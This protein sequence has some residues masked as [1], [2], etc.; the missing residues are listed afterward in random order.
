MAWWNAL[1]EESRRTM[2][3]SPNVRD[4]PT[5]ARCWLVFGTDSDPAI[6]EAL[7]RLREHHG[8]PGRDGEFQH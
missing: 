7:A 8:L 6:A 5:P 4:E 2:L 1:D 3:E